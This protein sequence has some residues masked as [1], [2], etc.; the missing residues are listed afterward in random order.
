MN[1]FTK[2]DGIFQ[3]FIAKVDQKTLSHNYYP[4]LP[5]YSVAATVRELTEFL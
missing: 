3:K 4:F 2:A 5:L 1:L